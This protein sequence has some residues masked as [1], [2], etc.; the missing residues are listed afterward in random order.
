MKTMRTKKQRKQHKDPY[1]YVPEEKRA[2]IEYSA[3]LL[4]RL[5]RQMDICLAEYRDAINSSRRNSMMIISN[6]L[7]A[8]LELLDPEG[9]TGFRDAFTL[10]SLLDCLRLSVANTLDGVEQRSIKLGIKETRL[11]Q[12]ETDLIV[13]ESNLQTM[14]ERMERTFGVS[15]EPDEIR[16]K[17]D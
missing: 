10:S 14:G 13:R 8:C 17:G 7:R 5:E 16:C 2:M 6:R 9:E 12:K 11:E 15:A 3:R 4:G 1:W